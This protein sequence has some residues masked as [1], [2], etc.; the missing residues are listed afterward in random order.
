MRQTQ[1]VVRL[2]VEGFHC[3]P[4]APDEVSF[5]RHR[6]RH[7]FE[8]NAMKSVAGS[9]E[10]EFILLKREIARRLMREFGVNGPENGFPYCEFGTMSCEQIADWLMTEFDL[11]CCEVTED[12]ENGAVVF[13]ATG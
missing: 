3:W 5:L 10:I 1:I 9:R 11:R 8:I 7:T 6:H 4:E 12:G 2:E 13:E